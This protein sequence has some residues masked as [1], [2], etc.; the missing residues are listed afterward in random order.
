MSYTLTAANH[1]AHRETD[2]IVVD[3]FWSPRARP[4]FRV[5][6]EDRREHVRFVLYP[7]TGKDA[8][9]FF[10]HPFAGAGGALHGEAEATS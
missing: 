5:E 1:F 7:I 4:E 10:Y 6:V 9:S 3:L 2:G 8:I